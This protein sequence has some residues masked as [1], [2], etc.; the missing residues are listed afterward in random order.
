MSDYRQYI[1]T[2]TSFKSLSFGLVNVHNV[3]LIT[4]D[5]RFAFFGY[6]CIREDSLSCCQ[7]SFFLIPHVDQSQAFDSCLLRY[8]GCIT[9]TRMISPHILIWHI[10]GKAGFMNKQV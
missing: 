10:G 9:R 6:G 5:N 4:E 1:A 7:R 2:A 3:I 8:M